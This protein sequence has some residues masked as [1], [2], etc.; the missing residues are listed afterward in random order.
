MNPE[1]HNFIYHFGSKGTEGS[2]KM[3]ELL[4]GK[5]ANLAEMCR[6]GY[7]VPPGFTLSTDL[8]HLFYEGGR[9][10]PEKIR[11]QINS[12][13]TRLEEET[14]KTFGDPENPLLVSVRSGAPQSMPGMMDTIL[15]LGL[16]NKTTEGLGKLTGNPRFAWD[17]YRRFVQMYSEVVMGMNLSLLEAYLEDCKHKKNYSQDTEMSAED[18]KKIVSLFKETILQ[19]TGHVFPED[20]KEQLWSAIQAVFLSWENPRAKVYRQANGESHAYGT[21]VNIQAMVFG[22]MGDDSATGVVFT[23]N[24]STGE[25]GI[26]GEFLLNAQGEDIVAGTRTPL[27][28]AGKSSKNTMAEKMPDIFKNLKELCQQL[29][30]HYRDIQDI[31]FTIEKNKLWLLQTRNGKC[32][33]SARLKIL[34]DFINE[35]I[36]TEQEA[37]LLIPPDSLEDLLHPSV[38]YSTEAVL[39]GKALP[40]SPGGAVGKIVF[41]S[42]EAAEWEKR[43]ETVIL[44]RKETSPEDINGMLSSQGIL[45]LRGGMTS[46][47]AVVARSMGKP[48]IVGCEEGRIDEIKKTISFSNHTLKRG[49]LYHSGRDHRQNFN[50]RLKNKNLCFK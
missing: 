1:N 49:G 34:N 23:R 25:K 28:I 2:S 15:N 22:N 50:G 48:C 36:L 5:G 17:S 30:L 16:N 21:A 26:F 42:K 45:T 39:L 12:S 33:A 20:P 37:L 6:L 10:L 11:E 14:G 13:L 43:G 7:P 41:S 4:G 40:A 38:D 29:E 35:G 27:P 47:A 24:P 32:A 44:V 8:C 3:R 9:V 18:W 31:E 19:D 46:H